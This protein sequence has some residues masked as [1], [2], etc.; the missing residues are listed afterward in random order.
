MHTPHVADKNSLAGCLLFFVL[1][2]DAVFNPKDPL[3]WLG[4]LVGLSTLTYNAIRI[5][6]ELKSKS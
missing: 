1:K 4:V 6:K 5:Y 3:F 2:A